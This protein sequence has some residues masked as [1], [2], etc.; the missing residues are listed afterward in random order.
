[1]SDLIKVLV[2]D[3]EE[4]LRQIMEKK[5]SQTG[6]DVV[7]A[8]DGQDAWEKIVKHDP[9]VIVL[10]LMMPRLDGYEVLKK[11]RESPPSEKWQPVIIVSAKGE[12]GDIHKGLDMDADHYL[13]KPCSLEDIIKGIRLMVSLIPQRRIATETEG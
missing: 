2:A 11:L 10:D 1:M 12:L 8:S 4:D 5:I 7:S 9:D 13:T 3:D 6:Y